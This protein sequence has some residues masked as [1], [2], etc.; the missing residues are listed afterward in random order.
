MVREKP[1]YCIEKKVKNY[2][3]LLLR[4]D[5]YKKKVKWNI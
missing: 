3:G 2:I 4:N 5:V 1:L